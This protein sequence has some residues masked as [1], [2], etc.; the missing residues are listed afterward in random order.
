MLTR[1][2][3]QSLLTLNVIA[4]EE[5]IKPVFPTWQHG[6]EQVKHREG[7]H[8]CPY[9]FH[10]VVMYALM[11]CGIKSERVQPRQ[12]G[13]NGENRC[14][15]DVSHWFVLFFMPREKL[16]GEILPFWSWGRGKAKQ[17]QYYVHTSTGHHKHRGRQVRSRTER[18]RSYAM[19]LGCK[20]TVL[21][22]ALQCLHPVVIA[23]EVSAMPASGLFCPLERV[24]RE[25]QLAG[26]LGAQ[27]AQARQG[28][29][30]HTS[31]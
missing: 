12:V 6:W 2:N 18:N 11:C 19:W 15:G 26:I 17:Q 27:L 25:G 24:V 1:A 14:K 23:L 8:C 28:L 16:P 30:L 4:P 9:C 13:D 5:E 31:H 20:C 3:I 7:E 21:T 22:V 29:S 10:P